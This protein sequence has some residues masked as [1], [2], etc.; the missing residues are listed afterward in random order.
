MPNNEEQNNF[1]NEKKEKKK[2]FLLVLFL[3]IFL[4]P[5]GFGIYALIPDRPAP[6]VTYEVKLINND[7]GGLAISQNTAYPDRTFTADITINRSIISDRVL[8]DSLSSSDVLCADKPINYTYKASSDK[9]SA[10][11]TIPG[12]NIK[13]NITINVPLVTP[14]ETFPIILKA[15][16]GRFKDNKSEITLN[17]YA[18]CRL[19]D[20]LDSYTRPTNF[21]EGY[22]FTH[23]EQENDRTKKLNETDVVPFSPGGITYVA[24]CDLNTYHVS[25]KGDGGKFNG[26]ETLELDYSYDD[27]INLREGYVDPTWEGHTFLYYETTDVSNENQRF[28]PTDKITI[29]KDHNASFG[30]RAIY[31]NNLEITFDAL[32]GHFLGG[33]PTINISA[34]D[35]ITINEIEKKYGVNLTPISDVAG[36]SFVYY[37]NGS[38]TIYPNTPLYGNSGTLTLDAVYSPCMHSDPYENFA[39]EDNHVYGICPHCFKPIL[40]TDEE[41]LIAS[42]KK[43][44]LVPDETDPTLFKESN[45]QEVKQLIHDTPAGKTLHLYLIGENFELNGSRDGGIVNVHLHGVLNSKNEKISSFRC[46]GVRADGTKTYVGYGGMHL[47]TEN[48]IMNGSL[49]CGTFY[50]G[51]QSDYLTCNNCDFKGIQSFYSPGEVICN[52]C[53]FDST[54]LEYEKEGKTKSEYSIY[55]YAPYNI[56]FN[57]CDFISRGKALKLYTEGYVKNAV[58][59]LNECTFTVVDKLEDKAAIQIDSTYVQNYDVYITRCTQNGHTAGLYQDSANPSHAHFIISE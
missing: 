59:K 3:I 50:L 9:F 55:S 45:Q 4:V 44:I 48:L 21:R 17:G 53:T 29:D 33:D 56:E 39:V 54:M 16:G 41:L 20:F 47:I 46:Y 6:I 35:G 11:I 58:Y 52:N 25:F 23:W 28:Y 1:N 51:V 14:T 31:A 22:H 40:L 12:E 36:T 2:R 8:P 38:D 37:K 26:S 27:V 42:A 19:I 57:S 7:D 34:Y 43:A 10:H 18:G 5:L 49:E 24:N 13:G 15:N 30:L 32:N